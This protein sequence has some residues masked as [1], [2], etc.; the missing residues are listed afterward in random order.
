[1]ALPFTPLALMQFNQGKIL[2][3]GNYWGMRVREDD[4]PFCWRLNGAE[5]N[6]FVTVLDIKPAR[7]GAFA[8]IDNDAGLPF[9]FL[10]AT[11]VLGAPYGLRADSIHLR[12][13]RPINGI[14]T[15][16]SADGQIGHRFSGQIATPDL[17]NPAQWGVVHRGSTAAYSNA[18]GTVQFVGF[19]LANGAVFQDV[20]FDVIPDPNNPLPS[21]PI[22]QVFVG[23]L[24]ILG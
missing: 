15:W 13:S 23:D 12:F 14:G 8:R 17:L 7:N 9:G 24:Q 22:S 10:P 21:T 2:S 19:Q 11:G 6:D 5:T 16:I 1:M 18:P 3:W 4:F 20:F